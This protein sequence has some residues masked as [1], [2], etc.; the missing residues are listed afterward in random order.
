MNVGGDTTVLFRPVGEKELALIVGRLS[1]LST[2]P[3]RA[4]DF[5]S[6][7]ERRLRGSDR[8]RLEHSRRR[9]RLRERF[10]VRSAF[11]RRYSRHTVGASTHGEYWI[12]AEELPDFNAALVGPIEVIAELHG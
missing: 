10:R 5:L 7:H 2:P 9:D 8:A 11:L 3:A 6:R 12:P 1:R 4:A